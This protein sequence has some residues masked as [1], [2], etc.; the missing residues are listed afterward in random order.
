MERIVRERKLLGKRMEGIVR[1]RKLR[2]KRSGEW[3]G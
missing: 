1:E 2:G 3:K